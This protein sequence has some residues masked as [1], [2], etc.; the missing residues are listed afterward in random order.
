MEQI[1]TIPVNEA[2]E[3][4]I[5][6]GECP[7]C[8]LEDELE[9]NEIDLIL[10]ASMM[11]PDVRK[12]TNKMGFCRPHYKIMFAASKKLPLALILE[13]HLAEI[14]DMMPAPGLLPA[15]SGKSASKKLSEV[16]CSCYVCSRMEY[17]FVRMLDTAAYLWDT[18]ED[19]RRKCKK[20]QGYC[21]PH[22]ARF[23]SA[24]N[25]R[26]KSKRFG[27]FYKS[28]YS[29]EDKHI[30]GIS[31]KLS[32]FVKSFDYRYANVPVDDAK[33]AVEKTV[34]LISGKNPK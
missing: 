26:M 29:T 32:R 20:Q 8:Q 9:S 24:A 18:D 5:E 17:N 33:D 22:T 4:C 1:Y 19:F 12:K 28:I 27:E 30:S 11:E 6:T 23:V 34:A 21:I 16:S 3:K 2:F 13:S 14:A 15:V 31:D 7:F 10:G 25:A